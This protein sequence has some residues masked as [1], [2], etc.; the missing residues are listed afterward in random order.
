VTTKRLVEKSE[1]VV[2]KHGEVCEY[3]YKNYN[4][5]TPKGEL[6]VIP[7]KGTASCL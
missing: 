2:A 7:V 6:I 3:N 4:R 1:V 5:N